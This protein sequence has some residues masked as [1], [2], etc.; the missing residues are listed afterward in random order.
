[1]PHGKIKYG[2]FSSW[3]SMVGRCCNPKY[4]NYENYGGKGV[5]VCCRWMS[6]KNFFN[7][8]GPRPPGTVLDRRDNSKDYSPKNCKWATHKEST[9]NRGNTVLVNGERVFDMAKRLKIPYGR[10]Y[11][12]LRR[13]WTGD[14]IEADPK[15]R[16]NGNRFSQSKAKVLRVLPDA[17]CVRLNDRSGYIVWPGKIQTRGFERAAIG[18]GKTARLAWKS[19]QFT[20]K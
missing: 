14:E 1:M 4:G 2:A 15:S 12:R 3:R 19:V 6:F 8:M 13:G 9:A 17:F 18:L 10:I 20:K 7:D 5:K 16:Y 11:N